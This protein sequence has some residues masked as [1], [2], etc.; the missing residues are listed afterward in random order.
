MNDKF[1][2]IRHL[3]YSP[4]VGRDDLVGI[5]SALLG[6]TSCLISEKLDGSNV[7]LTRDDVFAR[8]HAHAPK[9][10]SYD[11]LKAIHAGI[12]HLIPEDHTVFCEWCW[13]VHSIQYDRLPNPPLFML[14]VR[15]E[16][17]TW[18][19]LQDREKIQEKLG[20]PRAPILWIGQFTDDEDLRMM[21]E[22]CMKAPPIYGP[23]REGVVV[24]CGAEFD[25]EEWNSRIA[26]W[27]RA[28]HVQTDEHWMTGPVRRQRLE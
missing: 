8:T 2:R 18:L 13:A 17:R 1:P 24:S 3:P 26:K 14:A 5:P 16:P 7:A 20:I 12:R 11:A 9:H 23:I 22:W 25:D 28:G 15:R 27:V 6:G 19:S 4:G 21:V 10:P